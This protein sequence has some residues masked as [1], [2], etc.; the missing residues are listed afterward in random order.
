[1]AFRNIVVTGATGSLGQ[2]LVP[3][4]SAKGYAVTGLNSARLN[5][6]HSTEAMLAVLEPLAP[7]IIVHAAA[8]TN[9]DG[10]ETAPELAMAVNK[11]GTRK[12]VEAAN[13]LG[14]I[15]VY[16]ST[17]YVF[18]GRQ[19]TPYT[20]ASKPNPINQ[21]GLSKYYGELMVRELSDTSYIVRTSW[22]Y[23]QHGHNFVQWLLQAA[24]QGR[25][26]GVVA[27]Q[28]G[29]PTWT[30]SL[31]HQIEQ[32]FLSG[33]YGVY[34]AVDA[35]PVPSPVSRYEQALAMCQ[36][37]GLSSAYI[38]P[39]E[40]RTLNQAALRPRCTVLDASPLVTPHW[41]TSFE[42]FLSQYMG[43]EG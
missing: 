24:Q 3:F 8:Y 9:V 17:D 33:A 2:D 18:D 1:M 35:G 7:Q 25:E 19:E 21:Y 32:V 14:A 31:C 30:G 27:N 36:A 12:L 13:A 41:R 16:I 43:K 11:E 10:A 15:V 23:G 28:I 29:I 4:L 37:A 22:L 38:K 39:V 40:S 26:V 42:S 6:L 34:H 20:T 5:L